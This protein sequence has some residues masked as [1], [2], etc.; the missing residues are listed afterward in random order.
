MAIKLPEKIKKFTNTT[1]E[2]KV[3]NFL[4]KYHT[5]RLLAWATRPYWGHKDSFRPWSLDCSTMW[6]PNFGPSTNFCICI[7]CLFWLSICSLNCTAQHRVQSADSLP[8]GHELCCTSSHLHLMQ[9]LVLQTI[10]EYHC[11]STVSSTYTDTDSIMGC[12][13]AAVADMSH[14]QSARKKNTLVWS[15]RSR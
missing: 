10:D 7:N 2:I 4:H 14:L 5:T 12:S 3:F 6:A 15:M 8:N 11:I 1:A 9:L 13:L